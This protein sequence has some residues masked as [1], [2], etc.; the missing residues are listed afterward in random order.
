[1]TPADRVIGRASDGQPPVAQAGTSDGPIGRWPSRR[2]GPSP[3][4]AGSRS[5]SARQRGFG[6]R[7]SSPAGSPRRWSAGRSRIRP[8]DEILARQDSRPGHLHAEDAGALE[9]SSPNASLRVTQLVRRL[10]RTEDRPGSPSAGRRRSRRPPAPCTG[11]PRTRAE[12]RWST[13]DSRRR[14]LRPRVSPPARRRSCRLAER[15]ARTSTASGSR[16]CADRALER[17]RA[18]TGIVAAVGQRRLGLRRDLELSFLSASRLRRSRSG[19][20]RSARAV[21]AECL[22]NPSRRTRS[23]S[24]GSV[25]QTSS[26]CP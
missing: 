19:S 18:E 5:R 25:A 3:A 26:A 24:A 20:R 16:S 12:G 17:S 1:M 9:R 10:A 2:S 21:L 15:P 22:Q 6:R 7:R 11:L 4:Q 14:S 13:G 8:G 23:D